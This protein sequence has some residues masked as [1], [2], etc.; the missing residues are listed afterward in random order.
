MEGLALRSVGTRGLAYRTALPRRSRLALQTTGAVQRHIARCAAVGAIEFRE[1]GN[2][3]LLALAV[4]QSRRAAKLVALRVGI[5]AIV[6]AA[7]VVRADRRL[8][9]PAHRIDDGGRGNAF[10]TGAALLG[11]K[12]A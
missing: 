6:V 10:R 11:Q 9:H 12:D 8:G 5:D 4:H 7:L 2:Q 1:L 3:R